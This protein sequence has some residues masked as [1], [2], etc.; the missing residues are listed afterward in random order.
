MRT[1]VPTW[2]KPGLA[3]YATVHLATWLFLLLDDA[4]RHEGF[5]AHVSIWDGQ[6]FLQAASGLPHQLPVVNGRVAQNPLAFFPLFPQLLRLL[7]LGHLL[8]IAIVGVV[9]TTVLGATAVWAV[10]RLAFEWR[11]ELA[12]RRV[13]ILLALSPGAFCFSL[14]YSEGLFITLSAVALLAMLQQ[15][16]WRAGLLSLLASATAAVGLGLAVALAAVVVTRRHQR[17]LRELGALVMSSLSFI[18]Y[19]SF[20]GWR[21]KHWNAWFL[22]ERQ[23]WHSYFSPLYPAE[24]LGRFLRDPA[25]LTLTQHLLFW[26]TVVAIVLIVRAWRSGL[27]T[28]VLWYTVAVVALTAGSVPV[29][30]RPRFLLC[31]FPLL[32]GLTTTTPRWWRGVVVVSTL[33][34]I[35]MTVE[36]LLSFAIFP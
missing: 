26:C 3:I 5:L 20:V 30:P 6:W 13:G 36:E 16:W 35:A 9:V 21:T 25:A 11:G 31:A 24:A 4:V 14:L 28:P 32:F 2:V 15:R 12:A 34:L 33:G 19:V 10:A 23:G 29:G 27:P 18:G 1:K 7:S 22:T 8:R 17:P